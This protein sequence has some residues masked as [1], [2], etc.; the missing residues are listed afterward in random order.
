MKNQH[1]LQRFQYAWAG[2]K[3]SWRSEKSFR[4]HVA[5]LAAILFLLVLLRPAAAWWALLLLASACAIA[6]ELVNTAVEKLVDYLHPQQHEVIGIV[7]D[8]LAGA[9]LVACTAEAVLV[10]VFLCSLK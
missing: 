5:A 7:K 2:L 3:A 4:T 8:T 10:A 6:I 9:V 1:I